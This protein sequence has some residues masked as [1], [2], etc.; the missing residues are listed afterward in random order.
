VTLPTAHSGL[1]AWW[2]GDANGTVETVSLRSTDGALV[3]ALRTPADR[4][5]HLLSGLATG[6][7]GPS[8]WKVATT[9]AAGSDA[10]VLTLSDP[11]E[12]VIHGTWSEPVNAGVSPQ[13]QTAKWQPHALVGLGAGSAIDSLDLHLGWRNAAGGGADFGIAVASGP[14]TFNYNNAAYQATPGEQTESRV[15]DGSDLQEFGWRN[16]TSALAGPSISTGGF[17]TTG[18]AYTLTWS[19][20]LRDTDGTE[21]DVCAVLGP[22]QD[23]DVTEG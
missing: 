8:H 15:V 17:A 1:V 20:D 9:V 12:G 11:L 13:G 7:D 4:D 3:L 5:V 2:R 22:V 16:E 23:V 19:A 21:G 6:G 10:V 18:I 14:S